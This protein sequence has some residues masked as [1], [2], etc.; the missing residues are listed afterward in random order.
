MP[1]DRNATKPEDKLVLRILLFP[2]YRRCFCKASSKRC[3]IQQRLVNSNLQ[4]WYINHFALSRPRITKAWWFSHPYTKWRHS[5]SE[6][7]WTTNLI[8]HFCLDRMYITPISFTDVFC[9][10]TTTNRKFFLFRFCCLK[11]DLPTISPRRAIIT[12]RL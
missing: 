8:V 1:N 9:S 7:C 6:N 12:W 4:C 3:C 10:L 5:F 2:K 11:H